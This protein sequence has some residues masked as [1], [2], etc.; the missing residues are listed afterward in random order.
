MKLFEELLVQNDLHQPC[1]FKSAFSE[2]DIDPESLFQAIQ[3]AKMIDI[4]GQSDVKFTYYNGTQ[5]QT[6][7]NWHPA[8]NDQNLAEY[9]TRL[10]QEAR[11]RSSGTQTFAL[12]FH[13]IQKYADFEFWLKLKKICQSFNQKCGFSAHVESVLFMGNYDSTPIGIHKDSGSVFKFVIKGKKQIRLWPAHYFKSNNHKPQIHNYSEH[14]KDSILIEGNAG[15][16]IYWPKT[17]WHIAENSSETSASLSLAF[18]EKSQTAYFNELIDRSRN[19]I[20]KHGE[21]PRLIKYSPDFMDCFGKDFETYFSTTFNY[22][23]MKFYISQNWL[24]TFTAS[25]FM[26]IPP[27]IQF[28]LV[29][30]K[31]L[32]LTKDFP[33]FYKLLDNQLIVANNGRSFV[34][35]HPTKQIFELIEFINSGETFTFLSLI[36][37]F[38]TISGSTLKT[39]IQALGS[40]GAFYAQP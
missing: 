36:N 40:Y 19:K 15:D 22:K 32:R 30:D 24:E 34:I 18:Y 29:D 26:S 21:T 33:V 8:K 11:Q 16:I 4:E 28:S 20:N 35:A 17:Y 14:L 9:L 31:P 37:T 10:E 27:K 1:L 25:G 23:K 38:K 13:D 6:N 12:K 39:V 7:H 5:R 2:N 3:Q